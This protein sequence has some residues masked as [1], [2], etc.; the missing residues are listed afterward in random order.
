MVNLEDE[1]VSFGVK[2]FYGEGYKG[3]VFWDIEIFMF[4]FYIYINLK[5]VRVM[6][7][8]RYNF[9]DAVRE[10]VRKNGYKGV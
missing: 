6:L 1:C 5:A 8:Y 2:G 7:M 4:L 10:N 9:L 3:Y